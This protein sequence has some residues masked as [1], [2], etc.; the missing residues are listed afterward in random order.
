MEYRARLK[1]L[2]YLVNLTEND[3][4]RCYQAIFLQDVFYKFNDFSEQSFKSIANLKL[5][6]INNFMQKYSGGGSGLSLPPLQD[7]PQAY[8][9]S[10][11]KVDVELIS[12]SVQVTPR[13]TQEDMDRSR[14]RREREE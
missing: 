7:V 13:R 5:A 12:E 11:P 14:E 4:Q 1:K 8:P 6:A 10:E 2:S 9:T 3:I